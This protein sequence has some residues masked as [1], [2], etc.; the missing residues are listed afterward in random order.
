MG[1][2]ADQLVIPESKPMIDDYHQLEFHIS[3]IDKV[4]EKPDV[5]RMFGV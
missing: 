5:K 1:T 4:L 3:E 2:K